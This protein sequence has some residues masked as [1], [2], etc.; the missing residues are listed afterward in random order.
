[1]KLVSAPANRADIALKPRKINPV[2][3][4]IFDDGLNRE[5]H[6]MLHEGTTGKKCPDAFRVVGTERPC[7]AEGT[8]NRN[9]TPM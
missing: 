5:S 2:R 6:K 4:D 7:K 8:R 1:M 9:I 3:T